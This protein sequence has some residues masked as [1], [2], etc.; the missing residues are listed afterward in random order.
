LNQFALPR[1]VVDFTHNSFVAWNPR[2]LDLTGCSE[3]TIRSAKPEELL[4]FGESWLP[5]S[6][7]D[8]Q[9]VEFTSCATR[10]PFGTDPTPGYIIRTPS[11]FGYAMLEFSDL[12]TAQFEQGRITGQEE[13]RNRIIKAY[14]EEVS[15]SIIAALFLMEEA[16]NKLEETGSPQAEPISKASQILIET[17]EKIADVLS[18]PDRDSQT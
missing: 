8:G 4:A 10:R 16:K 3:D 18:E 5:L 13:E 15:S 12:R 17:T 1:A 11:N 6:K 7:N 2:F 14:H 9:L